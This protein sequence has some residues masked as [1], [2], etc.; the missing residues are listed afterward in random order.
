MTGDCLVFLLRYNTLIS[1][2]NVTLRGTAPCIGEPVLSPVLSPQQQSIPLSFQGHSCCSSVP[3]AIS[4]KDSLLCAIHILYVTCQDVKRSR[5]QPPI[6][7]APWGWDTDDT[8]VRRKA[9]LKTS[10]QQD[11]NQWENTLT[12]GFLSIY[13]FQPGWNIYSFCFF[14]CINVLQTG[15]TL[16]VGA[17]VL[18][19][20][21]PSYYS[22]IQK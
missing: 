3:Q 20:S 6:P 21:R 17:T 15:I 22:W 11:M 2:N 1:A 19:L 12:Q 4:H 10:L 16:P 18:G 7:P 5:L 9:L 13:L 8:F 14:S